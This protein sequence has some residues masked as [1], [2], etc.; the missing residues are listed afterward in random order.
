MIPTRSDKF[1][2]LLGAEAS[3]T[4]NAGATADVKGDF[5]PCNRGRHHFFQLIA[6][7]GTPDIKIEA[8][9]VK[10]DDDN[11]PA[12]NHWFTLATLTTCSPTFRLTNTCMVAVRARRLDS[13]TEGVKVVYSQCGDI[14]DN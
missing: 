2:Y 4:A 5:A 7:S 3:Y 9:L 6:E 12:D 14:T 11:I 13:S 1:A 10:T 8:T